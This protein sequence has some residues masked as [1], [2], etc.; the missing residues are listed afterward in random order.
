MTI[1][2]AL[3]EC[4]RLAEENATLKATQAVLKKVL[5]AIR[6]HSEDTSDTC[7]MCDY[8]RAMAD[9]ALRALALNED[10]QS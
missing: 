6:E 1:E 10:A 4:A 5:E 2:T 3:T 9:E 8:A 7:V